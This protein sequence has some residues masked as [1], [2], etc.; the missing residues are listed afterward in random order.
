MLPGTAFFVSINLALRRTLVDYISGVTLSV[1]IL[2]LPTV[3]LSA[4][5]FAGK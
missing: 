4:F 5:Y 3:F 2:R 1:L